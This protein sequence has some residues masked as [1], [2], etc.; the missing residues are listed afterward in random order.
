MIKVIQPSTQTEWDLY[1]DL[2]Y[3]VLRA[4]WNQPRGTEKDEQEDSSFHFFALFDDEPAGV[5]RLQLNSFEEGQIR[6]MGVDEK[7]RGKKIGKILMEEAEKFARSKKISRIILQARENAV[8]FY[9]SCSYK[10]T[11]KT[12]LL[13]NTI[14]HYK[15][16]KRL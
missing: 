12:F 3:R 9:L 4:P 16:E 14:Q 15:M 13:W 7:F 6:F 8:D 1:Y 10:K 11:E 5:C 2:R